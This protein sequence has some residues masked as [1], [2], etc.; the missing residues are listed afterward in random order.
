MTNRKKII[1][2]KNQIY[3]SGVAIHE[4]TIIAN[5]DQQEQ[6]TFAVQTRSG[7]LRIHVIQTG[8][9]F[10]YEKVIRQLN[11]L[12]SPLSALLLALVTLLASLLVPRKPYFFPILCFVI[13]HPETTFLI[14]TGLGKHIQITNLLEKIVGP[15]PAAEE[16]E[17]I[18]T[19]LPR[20]GLRAEDV[21]RVILTHLDYDHASG[22]RYFPHAEILVHQAEVEYANTFMGKIRYKSHNW[23]S[24]FNPTSFYLDAEPYG[25]FSTSK[26]L[27]KSGDVRLVPLPGHTPGMVGVVIET[28]EKILFFSADH[29]V[30]PE[31]FK[32]AISEDRLFGFNSA[33]FPKSALATSVLLPSHDVET[34]ARLERM[35]TL[36][37]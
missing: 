19:Q 30:T 34:L 32:E 8:N 15:T 12:S 3:E 21:E 33:P 16:I 25:P 11:P 6:N 14:D 26:S 31:L 24:W 27:T 1:N 28:N 18:D 7:T 22:V 23:P 17:D 35:E 2:G 13:E 10:G 29:M 20:R 5:Q 37:L 36:T 4:D 9:M